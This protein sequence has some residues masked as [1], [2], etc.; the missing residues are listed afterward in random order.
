MIVGEIIW[1]K[2]IAGRRYFKI[3]IR[4]LKN[5]KQ[6]FFED[7]VYIGKRTC[8]LRPAAR[9][10]SI[11]PIQITLYISYFKIICTFLIFPKGLLVCMCVCLTEMSKQFCGLSFCVE[12]KCKAGMR[13]SCRT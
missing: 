12:D 10:N 11:Q 5:A 2:S 9:V 8:A 7:E 3:F 6:K 13:D 1:K 4:L